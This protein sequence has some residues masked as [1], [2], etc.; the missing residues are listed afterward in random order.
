[1]VSSRLIRI[2]AFFSRGVHPDILRAEMAKFEEKER[3]RKEALMAADKNSTSSEVVN[4][5]RNSINAP[6][7]RR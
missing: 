6:T 5:E 2:S 4:K 1:M 3:Q 7:P